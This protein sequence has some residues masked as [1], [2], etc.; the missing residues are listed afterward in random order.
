MKGWI[1]AHSRS[2]SSLSREQTA[3]RAAHDGPPTVQKRHQDYSETAE[4]LPIP[5]NTTKCSSQSESSFKL[6][7]GRGPDTS[8]I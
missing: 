6:A 1:S 3:K 7:K 8:V 2:V 4:K 5:L